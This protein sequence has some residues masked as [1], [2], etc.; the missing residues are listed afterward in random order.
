M[1]AGREMLTRWRLPG[2]ASDAIEAH[3]AELRT[4]PEIPVGRLGNGEDGAFN[5]AVADL[6][7]RMGVL[8]DVQ[9]RIQR[10]RTGTAGQQ[11]TE[12]DRACRDGASS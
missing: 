7:R 1:L 5:K 3:Q 4:Q 8:T 12:H 10:D 11:H 6:P 9:R 2:D